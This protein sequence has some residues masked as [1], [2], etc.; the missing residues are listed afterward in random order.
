M[1]PE[2]SLVFKPRNVSKKFYITR[3][4]IIFSLLLL[5]GLV[6]S[7]SAKGQGAIQISGVGY[8]DDSGQC[9]DPV[10]SETGASP[11]L[12]FTLEGDLQGCWYAFVESA[13]CTPS[14]VY[15]EKGSEILVLD[16]P[17]GEG[18]FRTTYIFQSKYEGCTED[19]Y[20]DG[21]ELFGFCQHPIVAGSGTGDYEGVTGRM[22]VR[23]DVINGTLPYK[24]QLRWGSN[25]QASIDLA[26]S[27]GMSTASGGSSG[28]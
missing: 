6:A 10:T 4:A 19:G 7:V 5:L 17:Y 26:N 11:D 3:L 25:G 9:N 28:C 21:A 8:F 27:M 12:T 1:T 22:Y 16:G 20:P 18:T 2:N 24:G 15:L 14:G 23:D 13:K